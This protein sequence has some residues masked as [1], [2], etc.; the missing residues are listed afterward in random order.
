MREKKGLR[1]YKMLTAH[2]LLPSGDIVESKARLAGNPAA[3]Y[4][5]G[6]VSRFAPLISR[7]RAPRESSF[8]IM[9]IGESQSK[10]RRAD[11]VFV[12]CAGRARLSASD[13]FEREN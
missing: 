4:A 9:E 3:H 7:A 12:C 2:A 5:G 10:V 1:V 8:W 11:F 6:F 13:C